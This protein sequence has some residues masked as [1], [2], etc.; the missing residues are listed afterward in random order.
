MKA[1]Y[2][3]ACLLVWGLFFPRQQQF[4]LGLKVYSGAMMFA[5]EMGTWREWLDLKAKFFSKLFRNHL[6]TWWENYSGLS[7]NYFFLSHEID[8]LLCFLFVCLFVC[9]TVKHFPFINISGLDTQIKLLTNCKPRFENLVSQYGR[10]FPTTGKCF[11]VSLISK[12]AGHAGVWK[13]NARLPVFPE[14]WKMAWDLNV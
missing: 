10:Y 5:G 6:I 14:Y 12:N 3:S 2:K 13:L 1:E 9:F 7:F 11:C 8:E 4:P